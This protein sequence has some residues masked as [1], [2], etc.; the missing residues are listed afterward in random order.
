MQ[1]YFPGRRKGDVL[2]ATASTQGRFDFDMWM[3]LPAA[4]FGWVV[5]WLQLIVIVSDP[6]G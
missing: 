1:Q 2:S 3:K 5:G 6:E 4:S